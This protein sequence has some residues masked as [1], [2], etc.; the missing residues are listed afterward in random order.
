MLTNNSKLRP[1]TLEE[2]AW[3]QRQAVTGNPSVTRLRAALTTA[4]WHPLE[5]V[6]VA[7]RE[8]IDFRLERGDAVRG[9]DKEQSLRGLIRIFRSAGFEVGFS[10]LCIAEFYT[11]Q[12]SGS[13]LVAPL[14]EICAGGATLVDL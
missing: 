12:L 11:T 1:I 8:C 2:M 13:S 9:L 14:Q 4:G 10:E 5:L 6:L 7:D 3:V